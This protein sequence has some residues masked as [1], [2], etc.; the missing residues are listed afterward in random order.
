MDRTTVGMDARA[1]VSQEA[2]V[3]EEEAE[4]EQAGQNPW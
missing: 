1:L 3:T 4:S 2:E